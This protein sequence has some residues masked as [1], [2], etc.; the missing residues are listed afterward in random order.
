MNKK[1]DPKILKSIELIRK[2][3]AVAPSYLMRNLNITLVQAKSIFSQLQRLGYIS[4]PYHNTICKVN[5]K[6]FN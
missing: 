4:K 6:K 3:E 5:K 1:V 2:F